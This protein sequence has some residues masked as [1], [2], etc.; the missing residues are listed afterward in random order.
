MRGVRWDLPDNI[1]CDSGRES[2][3]AIKFVQNLCNKL[4]PQDEK[5]VMISEREKG[6]LKHLGRVI[7]QVLSSLIKEYDSLQLEIVRVKVNI[8]VER[9]P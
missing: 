8:H 7:E 2:Y 3:C 4:C 9:I 5:G 6:C 1:F